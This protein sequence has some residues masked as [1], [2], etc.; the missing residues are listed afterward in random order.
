MSRI[1]A[2]TAKGRRIAT[3][4]GRSTRPTTDRVREALFSS[5]EATLGSLQGVHF[6]ELYAGSGAVSLEA[7]S[8]N[9]QLATLVEL[10]PATAALARRNAVDLG[11]RAVEVVT[12]TVER[13]VAAQATRAY[14]VVFL[15]PPYD[16]ANTAVADVL[17]QLAEHC[18]LADEALVVVERSS[19]TQP[20]RWPPHFE[21]LRSRNYGETTLWYGRATGTA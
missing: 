11:F 8:R 3:P 12:G 2:G 7:M 20:L 9:A 10:H 17:T 1:V 13:F 16:V 19:R 21:P 6:L 4:P 14:D 5:I 18:W 15:D